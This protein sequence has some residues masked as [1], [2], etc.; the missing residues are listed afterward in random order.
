MSWA[1]PPLAEV[2][3]TPTGCMV[4]DSVNTRPR[5]ACEHSAIHVAQARQNRDTVRELIGI[6]GVEPSQC[7][8]TF[9]THDGAGADGVCSDYVVVRRFCT[10]DR[11]WLYLAC[12]R[13]SA[14][15]VVHLD[16]CVRAELKYR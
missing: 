13:H 7:V 5:C 6:F 8:T 10:G 1:P 3:G 2:W 12:T 4:H 14:V 11:E 9:W 15:R 16:D